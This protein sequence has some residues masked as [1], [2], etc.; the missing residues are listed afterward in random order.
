MSDETVLTETQEAILDATMSCIVRDGIDGA[1]L[2]SVARE[3]DVSLGLLSYH[4][5]DK[6]SLIVAAFRLATDR[7]F[8]TS[9]E[10]LDGIDDAEQRVRA[11]VRG[12]FHGKFLEPDYLALRLALWA[13]SRTDPQIEAVEQRLY[14]RYATK[15]STLI[16]E[17]RPGLGAEPARQRA[18]DVIVIQ[19]GLWLNWAR[20]SNL[21]DL[22]RGLDRCDEI[23]LAPVE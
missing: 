10:S 18:T 21:V 1:S 16:R 8:D 17:A 12:A 7:L 14:V 5:D 19:N 2:R 11:F 22:H 13:I 9:L 4:F 20:H 3:A 6:R 23:A 15:M